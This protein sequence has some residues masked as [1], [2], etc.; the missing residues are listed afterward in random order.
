MTRYHMVWFMTESLNKIS[1][2]IIWSSFH[3]NSYSTCWE[4]SAVCCGCS[5]LNKTVP[6]G[7]PE[8][9]KSDCSTGQDLS[10]HKYFVC[11]FFHIP[12][13]LKHRFAKIQTPKPFNSVHFTTRISQWNRKSLPLAGYNLESSTTCQLSYYGYKR[14]YHPIAGDNNTTIKYHSGLNYQA[15]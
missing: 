8:S 5:T 11:P 7:N 15:M 9:M 14:P 6:V 4:S 1:M 2:C 3:I 10:V 13:H 12:D